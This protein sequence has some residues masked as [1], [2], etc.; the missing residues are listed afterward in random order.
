MLR[1][2]GELS[3]INSVSVSP[4]TS[5]GVVGTLERRLGNHNSRLTQVWVLKGP[6]GF[7][8]EGGPRESV[9]LDRPGF[10]EGVRRRKVVYEGGRHG[11]SWG[12][13]TCSPQ[14]T[15]IRRDSYG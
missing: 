5:V 6:W 8:R 9:G 7:C 1:P 14:D 3:E 11:R 10:T 4:P 15:C 13:S 2:S 12:D